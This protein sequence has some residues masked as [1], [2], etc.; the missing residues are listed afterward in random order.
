M[1]TYI[2]LA[3]PYTAYRD[4]GSLDA[5]L[6]SERHKFVTECFANLVKAGLTIYCPITMTHPVDILSNGLGATFWYEFGKP[7][8]QHMSMLFVLMLPGW[9]K[10]E[11]VTG[12]IEVAISRKIPIVYLHFNPSCGHILGE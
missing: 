9:E 10:S 1:K 11:G 3:S 8:L 6:M 4:D 12:E 7:F 2:Y 5:I